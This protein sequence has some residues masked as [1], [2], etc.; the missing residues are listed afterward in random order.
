MR[1]EKAGGRRSRKTAHCARKS[2]GTVFPAVAGTAGPQAAR[3]ARMRA[4]AAASRWGAGSGLLLGRGVVLGDRHDFVLR[5]SCYLAF[6]SG[7]RSAE[8]EFASVRKGH[9]DADSLMLE[10]FGLIALDDE[11]GPGRNR[12]LGHTMA[13][14]G[15][16]AATLKTPI[17]DGTV[18]GLFVTPE[19][20]VRINQFDFRNGAMHDDG[21]LCIEGRREGVMSL[22]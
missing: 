20:G 12:G 11:L 1:E 5:R 4:S 8:E 7:S 13:D 15:I 14:Q 22:R 6:G 16:R 18:S 3:N 10:S 17:D 2:G 9:V 21:L 19:P